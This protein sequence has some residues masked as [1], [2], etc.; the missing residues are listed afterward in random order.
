LMHWSVMYRVSCAV[1]SVV[2]STLAGERYKRSP[3]SE[4]V[5]FAYRVAS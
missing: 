5:P 4:P 3:H 2:A 1:I